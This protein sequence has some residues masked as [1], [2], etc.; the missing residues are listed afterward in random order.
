MDERSQLA[1][2]LEQYKAFHNIFLSADYQNHLL[3]LLEEAISNKSWPDPTK[4]TDSEFRNEYF[5]AYAKV[6]AYTVIRDLMAKAEDNMEMIRKEL[7]KPEK[8][9]GIS[10]NLG[11]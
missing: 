1:K 6:K 11:K 9:Y 7:E 8:K 5:M 10:S 3:P 4:L 2:Q